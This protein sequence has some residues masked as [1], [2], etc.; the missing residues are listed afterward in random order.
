M[1]ESQFN[2]EEFTARLQK[3]S[4][5]ELIRFSKAC[6][7]YGE[8]TTERLWCAHH[9]RSGRIRTALSSYQPETG[10]K[11]RASLF[12]RRRRRIP[13]TKQTML[14]A[15]QTNELSKIPGSVARNALVLLP[16]STRGLIS[17]GGD[18]LAVSCADPKNVLRAFSNESSAIRCPL[19]FPSNNCSALRYGPTLNS[20]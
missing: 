20:M 15:F 13:R 16:F 1:S 2:L 9:G 5:A 7:P 6:C 17:S 4:D 10:A 3:M 18:G 11:L 19:S 8:V 12:V 14:T